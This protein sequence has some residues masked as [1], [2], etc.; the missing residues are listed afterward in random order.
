[1]PLHQTGKAILYVEKDGD[2]LLPSIIP[3]TGIDSNG[4]YDWLHQSV[5]ELAAY[6]DWLPKQCDRME[7]GDRM[8]FKVNYDQTYYRGDGY[9]T[10][11]DEELV[12][13]NIRKLW[14]RKGSEESRRRKKKFYR[15]K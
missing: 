6:C 4:G 2:D 1:M 15:S 12:F 13:Y 9:T 14:H 8:I 5:N 10:D 3:L 7:P 11:D